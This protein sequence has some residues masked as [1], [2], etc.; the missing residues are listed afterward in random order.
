MNRAAIFCPAHPREASDI[1]RLLLV[2]VTAGSIVPSEKRQQVVISRVQKRP[3]LRRWFHN[4]YASGSS[5]LVTAPLRCVPL[6]GATRRTEL[7]RSAI[8]APWLPV[9]GR[10][11]IYRRI[12]TPPRKLKRFCGIA[13]SGRSIE[14]CGRVMQTVTIVEGQL[15]ADPTNY[16]PDA[17]HVFG[18]ACRRSASCRS[19]S[20]AVLVTIHH[21]PANRAAGRGLN[22]PSAGRSGVGGFLPAWHS[23]PRSWPHDGSRAVVVGRIPTRLCLI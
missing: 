7:F 6:F 10:K 12:L 14:R 16:K 13:G 22:L 20:A 4:I 8:R 9:D 2:C 1:G 18:G 15:A 17:R 5:F 23:S 11:T 3:L 19:S 21:R